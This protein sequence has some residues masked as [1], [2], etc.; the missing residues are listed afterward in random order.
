MPA[1]GVLVAGENLIFLLVYP[2]IRGIFPE[3]DVKHKKYPLENTPHGGKRVHLHRR[4]PREG[5]GVKQSNTGD[6]EKN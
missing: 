5:S 2:H 1:M 6:Y 3:N 4:P